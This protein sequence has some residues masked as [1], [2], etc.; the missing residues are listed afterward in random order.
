MIKYCE[1][2]IGRCP[3]NCKLCIYYNC[4]KEVDYK[5]VKY[6]YERF[7]NSIDTELENKRWYEFMDWFLNYFNIKEEK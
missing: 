5:L 7:L 6:K 1:T 4:Q 3:E 2:C